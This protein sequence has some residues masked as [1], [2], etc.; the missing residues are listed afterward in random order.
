MVGIRFDAFGLPIKEQVEI[1][2]PD[3]SYTLNGNWKAGWALDLHTISSH[4]CDD[5]HYN[6]ER[7]A[8]GESLFQLKYRDDRTQVPFLVDSLVKFLK[9]RLVLPYIDV[10]LPTPSSKHRDYQPVYDIAHQVAQKLNKPF[11]PN[12]IYK[13]KETQELKSILDVNERRK[14]LSGAFA[15]RNSYQYANKK[16]LIIDDLFRSGSTLN[17]ISSLLYNQANV[18]NVYVVTLT[19]TRV[20]K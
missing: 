6:T 1:N 13:V 12:F 7:T 8:I 2:S 3:S 9:T 14:M 20:N 15:V 19:K 17:E 11:N 4:M 18:Q 16:I 5:N 10:I